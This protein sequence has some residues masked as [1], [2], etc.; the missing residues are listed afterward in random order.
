MNLKK[1]NIYGLVGT[2]VFHAAI[3]LILWFTV[4]HSVVPEED[5]GVVVNFGNVDEA[6]GMFEPA[7]TGETPPEETTVTPPPASTQQVTPKEN[8]ITQ[9]QEESVAIDAK[10]KE[11]KR[12]KEEAVKQQNAEQERINKATAERQR[13]ADAQ[14]R[15]QQAISNKVAGAFGIGG[16]AGNSQGSAA[17]GVGNQGSPFGNADH[18]A[19]TGVGGYGSFNLNGRS[20]GQGGLP[21]PAYT[22]QEEGRIVINITVDPKGSVIFAEIGRG[23]NIDN[24]TM[25]RSAIDAAK[26]ARFNS[27]QSSNNQSGTI[28]YVYKLK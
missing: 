4:L 13:V 23:T 21:R 25:R 19:N 15:K 11:D 12:R 3:L 16:G 28:T 9:D 2:L 14:R 17:S 7:Y 26:R 5:G 10:K 22:I 27:I 1:A 6:S 20:I 8:L 18:G 24:A